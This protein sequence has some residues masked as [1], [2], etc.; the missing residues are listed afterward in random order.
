MT[1]TVFT[2]GVTLTDAGWFNDT[3]TAVYTTVPAHTTAISNEIARATAAEA[4]LAPLTNALL[5]TPNL[6]T[7]SAGVLTNC[8]GTAAALN[9]GGNAATATTA[10]NATNLTG[11]GTVSATAT[12]GAGLTPTNATNATNLTGSGT[13]SGT[14]TAT[15]QSIGD[16]STKVATTAY[17]DRRPVQGTPTATTSGTTVT[18]TGI[19]TWTKKITFM[20]KGVKTSGTSVKQIQVGSGS[21][22]AT[23]YLGTMWNL[24]ANS[25]ITT[26]IGL[27]STVAADLLHGIVVLTLENS[28]TNSWSFS[29]LITNSNAAGL[30]MTAGTISLAG[31]LDRIGITT[32]N[33]TDTFGA[34]EINILYE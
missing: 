4:L 3:N 11:S 5:V 18:M 17:A 23:G 32:V 24:G 22:T 33:G 25:L 27:N 12:G 13:I 9:I 10:T 29:G 1:T 30:Y 28:S 20:L 14:S 26:G 19:P 16:N 8:S 31:A 15:T 34:G 7:P 6:G 2:N 21:L